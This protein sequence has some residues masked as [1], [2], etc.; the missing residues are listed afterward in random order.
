MRHKIQSVVA[1]LNQLL[2]SNDKKRHVPDNLKKAVAGALSIV[3]MDTV[4]AEERA[5]KYAALIAKEQAKANPDQDKIDSYTMT[6]EN[7]LR[8]GEKMG[9]RIKELHAAYDEIQNSEMSKLTSG[10]GLGIPGL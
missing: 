5:A 3:N 8:Q 9:Q 10:L 7:I 4:D 1:E 6:M 2:L